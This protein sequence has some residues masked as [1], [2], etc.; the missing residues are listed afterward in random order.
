MIEELI[1][2]RE[3]GFDNNESDNPY[4]PEDTFTGAS[5]MIGCPDSNQQ[6]QM[7]GSFEEGARLPRIHKSDPLD[8]HPSNVLPSVDH[9]EFPPR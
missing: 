9:F 1:N 2:A 5:Y 4:I 6:Q 7:D 3:R 8:F